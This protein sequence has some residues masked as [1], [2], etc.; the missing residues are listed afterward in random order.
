MARQETKYIVIHCSQTRPSQKIGVKEIDRWHRERG[1]LKV[2]YARVIKRDGTVEQGRDDDELQAH[3][4]NYNHISTSVCVVGG[5]KEENW[6][7]GE[8]NFTSEEWESLKKVLEELVIKYP[9]ARIVGHY[10]LD[11]RKTCPN[12]NVREYLLNEDIKGY[13]FAD[14]TVSDGDI[15][16]MKDAGEL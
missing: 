15:Q 1:W 5:A 2:G 10:E 13:K 12:F 6:K 11:E 3:V 9:E 7:L 16:E 14:S 8:D 4:K